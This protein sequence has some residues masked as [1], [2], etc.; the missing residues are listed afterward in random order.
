MKD[1]AHHYGRVR[2]PKGLVPMGEDQPAIGHRAKPEPPA[3]PV[4]RVTP[5]LKCRAPIDVVYRFCPYCGYPQK[6]GDAWYYDPVWILIL[7]FLALGPFALFLVWKSS[8]MNLV[9]KI[10]IAALILVYTGYGAYYFYK[11]MVLSLAQLREFNGL[12]R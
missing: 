11:V 1:H 4:S 2:N 5:C 9:A 3:L 12:F 8:K 7:A 10:I 6:K